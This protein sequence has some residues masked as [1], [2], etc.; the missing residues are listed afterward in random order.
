MYSFHLYWNSLS[1]HTCHMAVVHEAIPS[2]ALGLTLPSY[3]RDGCQSGYHLG[4]SADRALA[5][6]AN[7]PCS[8]SDLVTLFTLLFSRHIRYL[9]KNSSNEKGIDFFFPIKTYCELTL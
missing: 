8:N 1:H 4:S 6:N 2:C 3:K 5:C 9:N 7:S